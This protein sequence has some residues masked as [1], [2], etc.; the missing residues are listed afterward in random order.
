MPKSLRVVLVVVV[1]VLASMA[2]H[3]DGTLFQR[4]DMARGA[5]PSLTTAWLDSSGL[6]LWSFCQ[7]DFPMYE[8][9]KLWPVKADEGDTLLLGGYV[10]WWDK[11]DQVFLEPFWVYNHPLDGDWKMETGGGAYVPLN[12][13]PWVFYTSQV[14]LSHHVSKNVRAGIAATNWWQEGVGNSI[15]IGPKL[16]ISAGDTSWLLRYTFGVAGGAPDT[17][18]VELSIK[19]D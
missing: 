11:V 17:A 7:P 14:A 5:G 8:L 12:G 4:L 6:E 9:G 13:G 16:K 15:A 10:S 18:R 1:M 19:L 2:A 3:A